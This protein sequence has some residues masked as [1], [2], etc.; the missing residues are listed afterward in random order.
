M[1]PTLGVTACHLMLSVKIMQLPP[2]ERRHSE[3]LTS[4][5]SLVSVQTSNPICG[6]QRWQNPGASRA[7]HCSRPPSPALRESLSLAENK[8]LSGYLSWALI[9]RCQSFTRLA[10]ANQSGA[11]THAVPAYMQQGGGQ[12]VKHGTVFLHPSSSLSEVSAVNAVPHK[13]SSLHLL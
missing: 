2:A 4:H 8:Q 7:V 11:S 1:F 6:E 10:P 9:K 12:R 13:L 5:I 3:A